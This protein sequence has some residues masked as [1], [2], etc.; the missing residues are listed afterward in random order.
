[1]NSRIVGLRVGS[2]IFGLACLG[3]LGRLL[4]R[5]N[6]SIGSHPVPLWMSGVAVIVLA[7]LCAWLWKLSVEPKAP[8]M[9]AK[10]A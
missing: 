7:C 10:P 5:L 3:Q 1:M 6:V 8:E 9:P 2:V 4:L